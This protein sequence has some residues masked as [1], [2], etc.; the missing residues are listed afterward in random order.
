MKAPLSYIFYTHVWIAMAAVLLSEQTYLQLELPMRWDKMTLLIGSATLFNYLLQRIISVRVIHRETLSSLTHWLLRHKALA[1]SLIVVS[2]VGVGYG[3]SGIDVASFWLLVVIGG[4]SLLYDVPIGKQR[5]R[6]MG[7]IKIFLIGLVWASVTVWLPAFHAGL[8]LGS[9]DVWLIWAQRLL[10]ILAIT[11]P[12]D[13]RDILIDKALDLATIPRLIGVEASNKLS[14]WLLAGALGLEV[15]RVFTAHTAGLIYWQSVLG[16]MLAYT[17]TLVVIRL[18]KPHFGDGYYLG[19]LDGMMI[20]QFV[21]V[22]V[23]TRL[24]DPI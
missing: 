21:C 9:A 20:L 18:R 11:L 2:G 14:G 12:F 5:L 17:L 19:W 22:W 1:W 13:I 3:L 24:P 6:N 16:L 7:L 10:F 8:P 23:A 15:A 4:I